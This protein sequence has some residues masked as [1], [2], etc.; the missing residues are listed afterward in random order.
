VTIVTC[1]TP[2]AEGQKVGADDHY[3]DLR[4]SITDHRSAGEFAGARRGI[5]MPNLL[6]L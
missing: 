4:G 1:C 2:G 6:P 5:D 3:L